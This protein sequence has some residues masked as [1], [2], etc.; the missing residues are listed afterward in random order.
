MK[1]CPSSKD[2]R[3]LCLERQGNLRV[4]RMFLNRQVE[5]LNEDMLFVLSLAASCLADIQFPPT[6]L[7][8]RCIRS[9][10]SPTSPVHC[11][12]ANTVFSPSIPLLP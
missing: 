3:L 7:F 6:R 12:Q 9:E 2:R 5:E 11:I 10:N 8:A 4:K 1:T